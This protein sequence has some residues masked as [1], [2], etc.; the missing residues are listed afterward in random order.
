MNAVSPTLLSEYQE[1]TYQIPTISLTF[2][3]D[4]ETTIVTNKMVIKSL[5]ADEANRPLT[6]MADQLELISVSVDGVLLHDEEFT[7]TPTSLTLK[8]IPARCEVEIKN[9]IY[10]S[11][12]KELMGL[13]ATSKNMC[14]QCEAEGFRRITYS[15]DRPDSLS[16]FT[17]TIVADQSRF[18]TLLSNGNLI[19]EQ[20]LSQG[21]HLA[22]W[23]DPFPKPTYLF[24]LVAGQFDLLEGVFTTC[25]G[26][27][28]DLKIYTDEGEADRCRHALA[29]VQRSMRW[30]EARYGREYDLDLFM[31]VAV[32]DFNFGAM[33]NKGLNIFNAKYIL[34]SD[35]TAT[36]Q[37]FAG[38][39]SVVAHEYFHNWSGNRVTLRDWFQ[40][41][42]K[43]G[44][45]VYRDQSFDEDELSRVVHRID[46]VNKLRAHQ[47]KE[48]Q[49][50]MAHPVQPKSYLKIDNFYTHT[51]YGKGAE[52]IRMFHLI[53]GDEAYRAACDEYF[54]RFDGQAV[55]I[56]DF[57]ETMQRHTQIDL[58]PFF[59]WYHRAGTP[60]IS[61]DDH[62]DSETCTYTL[63][64]TQRSVS[65][66]LESDATPLLIPIKMGLI[67]QVTG[68]EVLLPD[69]YRGELLLLNE[70]E[71]YFKFEGIKNP[72]T[73]SL[74]RHFSAPVRLEYSYNPEQLEHLL[75]HDTDGFNRWQSGQ[76]LALLQLDKL[77]ERVMMGHTEGLQDVISLRYL[78]T[79][80]SLHHEDIKDQSYHARL[81]SLPTEAYLAERM[82]LIDPD[83]ISIARETLK[84]TIAERLYHSLLNQFKD[85]S[86]QGGPAYEIHELGRRALAGLYLSYLSSVRD[87]DKK[88][89]VIK[90]AEEFFDASLGVNM[91][92]T[93]SALSALCKLGGEQAEGALS[94]FH[95]RYKD[96]PLVINKWLSIQVMTQRPDALEVLKRLV[97]HPSFSIENPNNVYAS[98]LTFA[99]QNLVAFHDQTGASYRFIADQVLR[100]DRLNP[101]V[102]ARVIAPLSHWK[103][104]AP[105]R[106]E[107]MKRELE[108]ILKGRPEDGALSDNVKEYVMKSIG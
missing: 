47:F 82:S 41:S 68:E 103:R 24:A 78:E 53:L 93:V 26:R 55:T 87:Q 29:A 9:A 70:K 64:V 30:D 107:L 104:Y 63:K 50:P 42:L 75:R 15:Q 21:R 81:L 27:D 62:Y 38:I 95:A 58:K 44:L 19:E 60:T 106:S 100:L 6:L 52:I 1:P 48:D 16:V 71:R 39:S 86:T 12:N 11:K 98:L 10:P 17:T 91:T 94:C 59:S 57:A 54:E 36:D 67:D 96:S 18:P 84:S 102:A 31:I 90:V 69:L 4:P 25:T 28:V 77:I 3:L 79:F 85:L 73:P 61:V 80:E 56:E 46:T 92:D 13:Y 7:C 34:A 88:A 14:T 89:Q 108:R 83:A 32:N 51:I 2:E 8:S 35:E 105:P 74:L 72:V 101:M 5:I 23:H 40:L 76:D 22:T 49:G 66:E 97:D 33:E 99:T 37:D 20:S 65:E 43:E 45:T